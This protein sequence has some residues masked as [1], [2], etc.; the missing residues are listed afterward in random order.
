VFWPFSLPGAEV[1]EGASLFWS[2]VKL[3][4]PRVVL[5]FGS[6]TRD[7]LAMPRTLL[8]FCQERIYG[9][10]VVQLPRPQALAADE[11]AFQRVQT[12]L[13]S[14]HRFYFAR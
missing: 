4:D 11:A 13:A 10:L 8:P 7:A 6:D 1:K 2:G 9:R 3:L 14:L 12:F 5:L